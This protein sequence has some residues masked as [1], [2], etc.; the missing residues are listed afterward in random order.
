MDSHGLPP[1]VGHT[2][3]PQTLEPLPFTT[4]LLAAFGTIVLI[5]NIWRLS[6]PFVE[7]VLSEE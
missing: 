5:G 3:Q 4:Y 2:S 7:N 6:E 1:E